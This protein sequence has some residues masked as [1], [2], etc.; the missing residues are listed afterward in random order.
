[1][2]YERFHSV[3]YNFKVNIFHVTYTVEE[4]SQIDHTIREDYSR[5]ELDLQS[6]A[7]LLKI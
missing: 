6:S 2:G 3:G 7:F 4:N 1:M 5:L